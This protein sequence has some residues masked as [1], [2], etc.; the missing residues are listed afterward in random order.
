MI[1]LDRH[2]ELLNFVHAIIPVS[3][4]VYQLKASDGH[5]VIAGLAFQAASVSV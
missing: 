1:S 4:H 5:L 3:E 2:I